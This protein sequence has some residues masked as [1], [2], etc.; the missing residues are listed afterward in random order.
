MSAVATGG[1]SA[2]G[3]VGQGARAGNGAGEAGGATNSGGSTNGGSNNGGSAGGGNGGSTGGT[4]GCF[5][6]DLRTDVVPVDMYVMFDQSQSLSAAVPNASPPRTWWTSAQQ[7]F[8]NFVQDPAAAGIGVG[9]QFF[10]YKGSIQGPDPN[11]PGSS[12]YVPN[13][14]TPEV[15]VA[16]LPG[17]AAALIGAVNAHAPTTFTP[18]APALQ[19]AIRHMQ[20]WGPAH[21]GRQPAVVLVTDGFPT[22]CDPQDPS[23]I[24]QI[25]QSAY[26][27][28][29]RI[30]TFVVGLQSGEALD[31]LG[32]I[33]KAGG[34]GNAY[35]VDG[36]DIG[37][38]FV[39]A[40]LGVTRTPIDCA[41]SLPP[42]TAG[43]PLD[44]SQLWMQYVPFPSGAPQ[45]IPRV[46]SLADC[47]A[48]SDGW[49][50]DAPSAPTKMLTCPQ[51]CRRFAAGNFSITYGC[52]PATP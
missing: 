35:L 44:L 18:T 15:E 33:A 43:S 50:F 19:G 14:E 47:A 38:Q 32:Q 16:L 6:V 31:N 48:S 46:S 11:V 49:Y 40:L 27:G 26:E 39:Q 1:A 4:T 52:K 30:L 12:C 8:V 36:T 7:A 23:V 34:T 25:A 10:P 5:A 41:F 24:A 9:I 22:E 28:T 45:V 21:P 29:P 42:T 20:A 13:Y 2:S 51:T 37:R 3:G 17:N